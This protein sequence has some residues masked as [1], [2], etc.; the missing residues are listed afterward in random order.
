MKNNHQLQSN[1]RVKFEL[2]KTRERTGLIQLHIC[3]EFATPGLYAVLRMMVDDNFITSVQYQLNRKCHPFFQSGSDNP[4]SDYFLI[5]FWVDNEEAI[6]EWI[7]KLEENYIH[8][9]ALARAAAKTEQERKE[10]DAMAGRYE[11]FKELNKI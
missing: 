8:D 1:G 2:D 3:K 5:E 11:F 6:D 10:L 7:Q 9:F 4:N